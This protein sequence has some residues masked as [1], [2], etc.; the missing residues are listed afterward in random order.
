[1]KE[2]AKIDEYTHKGKKRANYRFSICS[3]KQKKS[4]IDLR[5]ILPYLYFFPRFRV[6][7]FRNGGQF[8]LELKKKLSLETSSV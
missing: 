6:K 8:T 1:M 4:T 3:K 7:T 5:N 2:V